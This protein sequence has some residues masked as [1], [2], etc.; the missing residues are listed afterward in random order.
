MFNK[1]KNGHW[2]IFLMSSLSSLGNL[3]LPIILVRI[4][5]PEDVG[6]YKIFFLH[7]SALPFI[8]MA[9]GALH[10][11][12]YWV[13]ME[14]PE[15]QRYL[16]ATWVVTIIFSSLIFLVGY[17][18]KSLVSQYLDI[19]QEYL[20]I[21][22]MS[23]TMNCIASH[24][25]E[26]SIALGKNRG[27]VIETVIEF[28][29]VIGFIL[30]AQIYKDI[31]IIFLFF[32]LHISLRLILVA[33][34]NKR[35]N[36]IGLTT[37]KNEIIKVIKYALPMSFTG[38]LGFFVE[39]LDLLILSS[40]LSAHDFAFY[41]MGCLVVPPLFM[42]EM[43][44]Q[45]KLIPVL[46]KNYIEK[47]IIES[48]R[49]FRNAIKDISFLMIPAIFGLLT[50]TTP[51]I[52]LLYTAKYLDSVI[53]LKIFAFSYILLML[54][55]DSV[56]RATGKTEWILKI[57][58]IITPLLLIGGYFASQY[59]GATGVLIVTLILRLIPKY[60]GMRLSKNIMQWEWSQMFPLK[61][62]MLFSA[63]CLILSIT[64][65]FIE[66]MFTSSYM[67]FLVCGPLYGVLYLVAAYKLGKKGIYAIT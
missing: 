24:F 13:G 67:W 54:P 11:V 38:L 2:P 66:S 50:F 53:F 40:H 20:F 18:L 42:L 7:Y 49:S 29:R 62:I 55:H 59:Y 25:A 58:L 28:I 34:L 14:Q 6:F 52:E 15:R 26:T 65:L 48:A 17:P 19:P 33:I 21:L 9:G 57:Y 44:V 60:W 43:S 64:S 16:N 47:N 10:S 1:L 45:K 30:I 36:Q 27:M 56:A 32:L 8:F 39:K 12:Y 3:F 37:G 31:Y 35:F 61:H 4:L 23:G 22:F 41:S 46:S 5:T 51:I 63:L